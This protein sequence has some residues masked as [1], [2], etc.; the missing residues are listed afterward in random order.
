[1]KLKQKMKRMYFWGGKNVLEK[2]IL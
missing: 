1:M 2:V